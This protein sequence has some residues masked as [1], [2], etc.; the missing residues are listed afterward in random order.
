MYLNIKN[1]FG[2]LPALLLLLAP[3]LATAAAG[4]QVHQILTIST[5]VPSTSFSINPVTGSWPASINL[6]YDESSKELSTYSIALNAV[7]EAGLSAMLVS[8]AELLNGANTIPLAV[9]IDSN[10]LSTNKYTSIKDSPSEAGG[11]IVTLSISGQPGSSVVSG[12]YTGSI[13][14]LFEDKI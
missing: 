14:L 5:T 2:G 13:Q 11:D 10:V 4:E 3:S 6:N 7:Y 9:S 8:E 1:V 12:S